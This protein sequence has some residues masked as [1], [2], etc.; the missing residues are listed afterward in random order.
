MIHLLKY[1]IQVK[2]RN[3]NLIFWPLVFPL[4]M[5]T[6]FYLA[7]GRI[8]EA[9]FETVPAAVVETEK[10]EGQEIFLRFLEEI[11]QSGEPLIAVEKMTEEEAQE[12]LG[13][14]EIAGIFYVGSDVR[15]AV[16][17]NGISQSILTSL[18]ESYENGK[19]VFTNIAKRHPEGM[20]KAVSEM[21]NYQESVRQ[22]SLGGRTT[23][24]NVQFFH[25]LIAMACLYGAFIGH[26]AAQWLQADLNPLAARRSSAPTSK[27]SM[28]LVEM[29]SSFLLHVVNVFILIF[30]I[31]FVLKQEMNGSLAEMIPVVL[32]GCIIGVSLG[33][34]VGSIRKIG[35]GAKIGI[36]LGI[37]MS[38]SFFA[39]LMNGEMKH[40]VEKNFPILNRINP[41]ALITDAFYCINVYED[42]ARFARSLATLGILAAGL[43]LLSYIKTRRVRYDSL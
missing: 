40:V 31:R 28:I 18:L 30:Y 32:M 6:L 42:S 16:A 14:K 21:K 5:A 41:A 33:I 15:L 38:C 12:S 35:E 4:I 19:Q 29:G 1:S 17:E 24:G 43:L 8:E 23:D 3:F 27:L 13:K 10:Q 11:E 9:D 25:A 2:L 22:V 26:G 7:F 36:L 34:F 37:S 39:G 20:A